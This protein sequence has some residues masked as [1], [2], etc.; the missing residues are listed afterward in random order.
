MLPSV[1]SFSKLH[2]SKPKQSSHNARKLT[3]IVYIQIQEL[4]SNYGYH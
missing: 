3:T 1:K 2:S 4:Y